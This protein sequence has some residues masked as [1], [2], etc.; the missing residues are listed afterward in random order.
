MPTICVLLDEDIAREEAEDIADRIGRMRGVETADLDYPD[1]D[2]DEDEEND[3]DD[4][5]ADED[6]AVF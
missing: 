6:E 4:G 3:D 2:E 5:D 1:E